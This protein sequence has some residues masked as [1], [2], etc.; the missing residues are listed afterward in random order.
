MSID[1]LGLKKK[2]IGN[3]DLRSKSISITTII[4]TIVL[5]LNYF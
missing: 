4:V 3:V 1:C 2:K 5:A